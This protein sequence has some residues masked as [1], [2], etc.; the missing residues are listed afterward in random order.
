MLRLSIQDPDVF[1]RLSEFRPTHLT[2]YA[3]VLHEIARAVENDTLAL[4]PSLEQVVNIS[5][6]LMPQAR[7]HYTEIF[8]AHHI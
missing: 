8:G 6:R 3:S 4:K 7:E 1:E 5:E 2:A